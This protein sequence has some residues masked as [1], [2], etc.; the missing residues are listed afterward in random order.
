MISRRRDSRRPTTIRLLYRQPSTLLLV[1]MRSSFVVNDEDVIDLSFDDPPEASYSP[2]ASRCKR[3][4]FVDLTLDDSESEPEVVNPVAIAMRPVTPGPAAAL[5]PVAIPAQIADPEDL[6][7]PILANI[8]RDIAPPR[9][10]ARKE[11]PAP[12]EPALWRKSTVPTY[13]L[14]SFIRQHLAQQ[15]IRPRF[16]APW[17]ERR[18]VCQPK[19]SMALTLSGAYDRGVY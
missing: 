14:V 19:K 16:G 4:L 9:K 3:K 11:K 18:I 7:L 8:P 17:L 13:A 1:A 12:V 6:P 15:L 2:P 10:R 5:P